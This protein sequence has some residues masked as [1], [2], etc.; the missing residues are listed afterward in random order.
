MSYILL[1]D[2]H[3]ELL[4]S[5]NR[6]FYLLPDE[7]EVDAANNGKE[8][9][10]ML[11]KRAYD[12]IV[13]DIKMPLMN[14][15]DL[16]D[17]VVSMYH[18]TIRIVLSGYTEK[19]LIYKTV[20]T[21]HHFL[22]KP[23]NLEKLIGVI[24]RSL[25]LRSQLTDVKIK[26]LVSGI[27]TLPSLPRVYQELIQ[28][29]RKTT[30]S[31]KEI[32]TIVSRDVG[33][34]AKLLHLVNSSFF[35]RASR[36]TSVMQ[37]IQLLGVEV[38]KAIAVSTAVFTP[39]KENK[40][41][42]FSMLSFEE[43]SMAIAIRAREL[44]KTEKQEQHIIEDS[45]IAGMMLEI[46][47]LIVASNLPEEYDRIH[48]LVLSGDRT[49]TNAEQDVLGVSYAEIGAYLLSL[50]GFRDNVVEAVAFQDMPSKS[51][52]HEFSPL[53]AAHVAKG[54]AHALTGQDIAELHGLIDV[55]YLKKLGH[56]S[57]LDEWQLICNQHIHE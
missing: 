30:V 50:W 17:V 14:G 38:V 29:L 47:R 23:V 21:A 35:G 16:L 19:D 51:D 37:A 56:F 20:G 31:M 52:D 36:V 49:P 42:Y 8:A 11:G 32:E 54:F 57:R 53:T 44:A 18:S 28:A 24:R 5:L 3:Q 10:E 15:A 9:I 34:T 46:G 12:V 26:S 40:S 45:F 41:S 22:T 43:R 4:N 13:T 39:F 25:S 33:L 7:W 6:A 48:G 1:V 2:D 55:D 27:R